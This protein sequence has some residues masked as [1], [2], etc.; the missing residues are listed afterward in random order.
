MDCLH[1]ENL[2]S[3]QDTT[4]R[5]IYLSFTPTNSFCKASKLKDPALLMEV[6][7]AV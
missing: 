6:L 2:A 5:K 4:G 1:H 3:Y 7:V